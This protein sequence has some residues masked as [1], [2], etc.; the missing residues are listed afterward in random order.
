MRF[1]T[2]RELRS[3]GGEIW[4]D[5]QKGEEAILTV[6]G[7]PVAVL[8][9]VPEDR[10]EDTLRALRRARAQAAVSRMRERAAKR[11][12]DRLPETEIEAE[13]RAARRE[14]SW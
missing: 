6:N 9:G 10:L 14:R 1:I 5:L 3:K 2:V 7:I 12:L 11:G 8:L 13:V 4:R